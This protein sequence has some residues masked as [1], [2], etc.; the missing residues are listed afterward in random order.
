MKAICFALQP[1]K[2]VDHIR[3]KQGIF[4]NTDIP[5][6]HFSVVFIYMFNDSKPN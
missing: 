1:E 4:G 2:V 6:C 3:V 5:R